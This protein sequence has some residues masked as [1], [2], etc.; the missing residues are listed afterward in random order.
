MMKKYLK[1]RLEEIGVGMK[2]CEGDEKVVVTIEGD[3]NDADYST[4]ITELPLKNANDVD[5]AVWVVK[6][7]MK[8]GEKMR[9]IERVEGKKWFEK[10]MDVV[11]MP[12]DE[13]GICHTIVCIDI[14][15]FDETGQKYS[16]I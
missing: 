11:E 15:Y 2:K 12:R 10:F 1:Q 5:I 4:R 16:I 8:H 6:T 14:D 9:E 13:Y 3:M 7:V